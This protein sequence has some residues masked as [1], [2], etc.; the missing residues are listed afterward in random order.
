MTTYLKVVLYSNI[1]LSR[2]SVNIFEIDRRVDEPNLRRERI[3]SRMCG[4][5]L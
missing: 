5:Y 1:D 4:L 2:I 3:S